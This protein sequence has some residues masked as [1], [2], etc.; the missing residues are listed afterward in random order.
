MLVLFDIDRT[1]L[2]TGRAGRAALVAAGERL[3]GPGFAADGIRF[4]GRIDPLIL[5]EILE[6]NG[7]PA[8]RDNADRL[9]DAYAG[10]L[11]ET[12]P[13]TT[14]ALP[15]VHDL[16]AA[17]SGAAERGVHL[18][19]GVLTGN[20]ERTGLIKLAAAGIDAG[21]FEVRVWGDSSPHDPP[22]RDHLPPVGMAR[23]AERVGR[24]VDPSNVVIIGDTPHDV[25]CALANGCRVLGVATGTPSADE[26]RTA[27]A[28]RV[29]D[30]LAETESLAAWI[31][32][33]DN[34]E[35]RG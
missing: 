29:V 6:L 27:G 26:L 22:S 5:A 10:V 23:Y 3:F 31:L 20:L 24:P 12:A 15:G 28:H 17:L 18:V 35:G 2:D 4:S 32:G 1:L 19:L 9:A 34:G 14:R 21:R 13:A 25:R 33:R 8:T 30:D 16:L 7:R 11:A